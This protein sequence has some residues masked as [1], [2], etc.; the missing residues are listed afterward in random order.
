M[1]CLQSLSERFQPVAA[2]GNDQEIITIV[3]E[4]FCKRRA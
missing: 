4:S 1:A 2:T 3:C